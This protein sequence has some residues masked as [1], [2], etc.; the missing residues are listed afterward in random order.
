MFLVLAGGGVESPRHWTHFAEVCG[1]EMWHSL[2]LLNA[3]HFGYKKGQFALPMPLSRG[4]IRAGVRQL[5][6]CRK[7][8]RGTRQPYCEDPA[9]KLQLWELVQVESIHLSNTLQGEKKG[10]G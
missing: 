2:V 10:S 7:Q 9:T 8:G 3:L 5:P 1:E 6:I 4:R